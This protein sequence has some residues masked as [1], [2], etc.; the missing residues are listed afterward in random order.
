MENKGK[1]VGL[2]D[3]IRD[4]GERMQGSNAADSAAASRFRKPTSPFLPGK[5]SPGRNRPGNS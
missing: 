1:S 3:K 2:G 5:G 4:L